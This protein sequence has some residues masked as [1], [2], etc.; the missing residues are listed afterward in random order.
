MVAEY[1]TVVEKCLGCL[2]PVVERK[3]GV[4]DLLAVAELVS[5]A[6][7]VLVAPKLAAGDELVMVGQLVPLVV[8]GRRAR[9]EPKLLADV[10]R[11]GKV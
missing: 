7:C 6:S 8:L 5:M 2:E 4:V 1:L 10:G 3:I 11:A 9:E